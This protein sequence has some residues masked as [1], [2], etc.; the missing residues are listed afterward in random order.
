MI[1]ERASRELESRKAGRIVKD[2]GRGR[3]RR[4]LE[5]F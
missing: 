1:P 2:G 4:R 3:R 5:R